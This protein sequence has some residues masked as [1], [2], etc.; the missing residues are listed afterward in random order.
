MGVV[1]DEIVPYAGSG[2]SY[3]TLILSERQWV[4][5]NV[6][7]RSLRRLTNSHQGLHC[8]NRK[9]TIIQVINSQASIERERRTN[10]GGSSFQN[11][12]IILSSVYFIGGYHRS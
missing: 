11:K 7:N 6:Q 2:L 3:A 4:C 5:L 9:A 1:F 8:K 12:H 10:T